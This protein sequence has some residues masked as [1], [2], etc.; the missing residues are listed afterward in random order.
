MSVK[1][2]DIMEIYQEVQEA[3]AL[4]KQAYIFIENLEGKLQGEMIQYEINKA[5]T[6][7]L[8][9]PDFGVKEE[10]EEMPRPLRYGQGSI[11]LRTRINSK[12]SVYQWYEARWFD[13]N[14][15]QH[16]KTFKTKEDA[17][18]V[19]SQLNTHT[20]RNMHRSNSRSFGAYLQSYFDTYRKNEVTVATAKRYQRMI[21]L[22]PAAIASTSLSKLEDLPIQQHLNAIVSVKERNETKKFLAACLKRAFLTGK[23][24]IDIG[25]MLKV[26]KYEAKP[27]Q[28]LPR[29]REAEFINNISPRYR[30]FVIGYLYTGC[31]LSELMR[32]TADD[33]D[34]VNNMI[35]IKG[36]N[37]GRGATKEYRIRQIPLLP[38]VQALQFPLPKISKRWFEEDMRQTCKKMGIKITPHDLR[39]TFAT[40]CREAGIELKTYSQW[41]G[42]KNVSITMDLYAAHTSKEQFQREAEKL[43]NSTHIST[44]I[45]SKERTDDDPQNHN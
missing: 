3:K 45:R 38:Q 17:R 22:L 8:L 41:L 21:D 4:I 2:G 33:V 10:Q 25:A 16:T 13:V 19:L 12:G 39:H 6:I 31:R 23:T 29:E 36:A 11:R 15:Q 20:T 35:T 18:R 5:R 24:K 9:P 14:G 43:K 27:R 42:H 30:D 26:E 32:V 1:N 34:R 7:T 37:K 44:H 40:R 28:I